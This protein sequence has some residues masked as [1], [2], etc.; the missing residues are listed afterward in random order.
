MSQNTENM[1]D[2]TSLFYPEAMFPEGSGDT[3]LNIKEIRKAFD[4]YVKDDPEFNDKEY[5][6]VEHFTDYDD[7]RVY[8][9]TSKPAEI[10]I[11]PLVETAG[12]FY[13]SYIEQ[14]KVFEHQESDLLVTLHRISE[15]EPNVTSFSSLGVES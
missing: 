2:V 1:I 5:C 3:P 9:T 14:E 11:R 6:F 15:Q 12:K 8:F 7:T 10:C 4:E 13:P